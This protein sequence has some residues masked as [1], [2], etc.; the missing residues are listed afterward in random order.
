MVGVHVG[1]ERE[2]GRKGKREKGGVRES[3]REERHL[4]FSYHLP[5]PL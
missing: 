5:L 3:E 4:S 2:R 1:R